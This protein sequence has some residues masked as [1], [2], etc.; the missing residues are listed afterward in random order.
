MMS[1]DRRVHQMIAQGEI[2]LAAGVYDA[3]SA[4]LA[5]RA[6]F[7]AV[8]VTGYG[9]SASTLGEPDFGLMT[10]TELI[11]AARRICNAVSIPVSVDGDT[12]YGGALNVFRLVEAL[13]EM[14]ARGVLLEDQ[15]WPKRC[16]HMRG[17]DVIP[18]GEHEQK[19]RAAVEAR[20]DYALMITAR[21]DALATHGLDEAIRRANLY[22]Q[23]GADLIFVE[24]PRTVEDLREIARQVPPPL[25]INCIEGGQT[26]LLP[27][28]QLKELGFIAVGYV[29]SGLY[30]AAKA[31]SD[32]YAC[33][34]EHGT[35]QP[36]RDR[37]MDFN[38]F[39]EVIGLSEKYALDERFRG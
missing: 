35:S 36:M 37:M 13:K 21:T 5:E 25:V 8:V 16:G 26:P 30:A 29:L 20:G 3:L 28:E 34:L 22:K 6:G 12:G 1:S 9:V 15:V 10:Q 2:F 33:L 39:A 14:G 11:D 17:K 23:A 27:L 32:V 31:L 18:A 4:K 24:A 19:I 38:E 7:H